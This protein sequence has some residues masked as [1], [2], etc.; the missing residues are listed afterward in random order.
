MAKSKSEKVTVEVNV[1]DLGV[2]SR[3]H[4]LMAN[5]EEYRKRALTAPGGREPDVELPDHSGLTA[6]A[7]VAASS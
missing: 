5:D 2:L 4:Y 3:H 7:V 1:D 6:G